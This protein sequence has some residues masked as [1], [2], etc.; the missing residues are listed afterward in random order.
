VFL[1]FSQVFVALGNVGSKRRLFKEGHVSHVVNNRLPL[2]QKCSQ[3][4]LLRVSKAKFE[5]VLMRAIVVA[6]F[7]FVAIF[8]GS[9]HYSSGLNFFLQVLQD[10]CI[11]SARSADLV[12]TLEVEAGVENGKPT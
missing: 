7:W 12:P 8:D 11:P 10:H 4:A 3:P 9:L 1:A 5:R 6:G 2:N